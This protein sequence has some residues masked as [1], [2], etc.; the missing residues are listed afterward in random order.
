MT[1]R[2]AKLTLAALVLVAAL[3]V[4]AS[5]LAYYAWP[6]RGR[7][8][9]GELLTPVPLPATPLAGVADRSAYDATQLRGRWTLVYA[10]P[11]HCPAT[12][13]RALYAARQARLA[14][15]KEMG[16]VE[17]L[18]L[19]TDAETPRPAL[20]EPHRGLQLARADSG[21]LGALPDSAGGEHLFLV[22]PLGNAM[23][24]FDADAV[25][26]IRGLVRDLGRLLKYS[27]LGRDDTAVAANALVPAAR[28][29]SER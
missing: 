5:Y 2:K 17:R 25:A 28:T 10:G 4:A 9:H 27:A 24:R 21:W 7:V 12:C 16:R 18:W 15:G 1:S 19:V 8:N 29:E 13:E 23:M 11:G 26:E 14:Q 20:L 22:D 3:P 6:P